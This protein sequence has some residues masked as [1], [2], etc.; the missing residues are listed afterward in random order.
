MRMPLLMSRLETSS[1]VI[2]ML[3]AIL[4]TTR[5]VCMEGGDRDWARRILKCT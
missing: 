1:N 2:P 4:L 3:Y 5:E